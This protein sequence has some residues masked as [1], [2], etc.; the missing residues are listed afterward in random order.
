MHFFEVVQQYSMVHVFKVVV[1]HKMVHFSKVVEHNVLLFLEGV[2]V[3]QHSGNGRQ[4]NG[5]DEEI[6]L[7]SPVLGH[8][9]QLQ[10]YIEVVDTFRPR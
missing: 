1:Q 8:S 4:D 7:F 5:A 2:Q 9:R 10:Q 3:V 6:C